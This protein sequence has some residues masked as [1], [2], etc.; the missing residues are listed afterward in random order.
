MFSNLFRCAGYF[1]LFL[2]VFRSHEFKL[3]DKR[4]NGKNYF[5][6]FFAYSQKPGCSGPDWFCFG[7]GLEL[8]PILS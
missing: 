7:Y 5:Q 6:L 2:F 3:T 1:R 4:T 8:S